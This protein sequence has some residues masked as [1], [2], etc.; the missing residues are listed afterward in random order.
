[1]LIAFDAPVGDAACVRRTSST[2]PL[3]ALVTLN[4]PM[5]V[6]LAI[7][8]AHRILQTSIEAAFERCTSRPPTPVEL[9]ILKDLFTSQKQDYSQNP[10]SARELLKT[11]AP[12][13]VDLSIHPVPDLAA[14]VAVAQTLLNL[15]ETISKN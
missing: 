9:K 2:T 5:S 8:L 1:M 11:Y 7:A 10:E 6:E 4:E 13:G 15:D 14:A 12:I 3:Q